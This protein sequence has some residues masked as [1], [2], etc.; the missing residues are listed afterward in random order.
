MEKQRDFKVL[1]GFI[2]KIFAI[3]FMTLD[4]IG[5]FLGTLENTAEISAILRILG[6]FSFPLIIFLL[7][8]GVRHTKDIKQYFMRLSVV[9]FAFLVGQL[10]FYYVL[11]NKENMFMSPA[12]DLLLTASTVYLLKRKD[13]FSFLAII[14]LAWS[15][16]TLVVRNYELTH[17]AYIKWVPFFLRPDYTIYGPL[18]GIGFYYAGELAPLFL[19]SNEG[20]KDFVGTSYEQTTK[21]IISIVVL[22]ILTIGICFIDQQAWH[23]FYSMPW[24]A[25][26]VLAAI[27]ILFY[28]GKRGYNAKWFQY[29]CYIYFPMHFIIIYLI[30]ALI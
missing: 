26:S 2:L 22:V 30:F 24:Q 10:F 20:T 1:S 6:R 27:P 16:L 7:V 29:G 25:Y 5:L 21:N 8:E 28:S 14:P 23:T 19:K 9:A 17:I 4:H 18:L 11:T 12:I 15:I 13:K 3:F